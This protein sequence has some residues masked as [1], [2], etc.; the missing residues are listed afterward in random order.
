MSSIH[1]HPTPSTFNSCIHG[2]APIHIMSVYNSYFC[3]LNVALLV[4][5]LYVFVCVQGLDDSCGSIK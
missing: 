4:L 2:N 3:R 1:L 5:S